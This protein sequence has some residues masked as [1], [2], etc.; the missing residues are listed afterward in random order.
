MVCFA[1]H[2]NVV[3]IILG[4][5]SHVYTSDDA[6]HCGASLS[7]QFNLDWVYPDVAKCVEK[8]ALCVYMSK[9]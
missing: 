1:G 9:N 4:D 8:E 7:K 5:Y 3:H 6:G 2:C